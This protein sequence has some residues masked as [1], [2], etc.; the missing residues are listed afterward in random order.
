MVSIVA[1]LFS[2][3]Y[4]LY[5]VSRADNLTSKKVVQ[6]LSLRAIHTTHSVTFSAALFM[7][8]VGYFLKSWLHHLTSACNCS[9]TEQ[10]EEAGESLRSSGQLFTGFRLAVEMW[11]RQRENFPALAG[12]FY[13]S[14][15]SY[16]ICKSDNAPPGHIIK[17]LQ[18]L[19]ARRSW[20]YLLPGKSS[21]TSKQT[22]HFQDFG[23]L[24]EE[25]E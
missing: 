9:E 8:K 19:V 20:N 7:T 1:L 14:K 16:V 15:S 10:R 24:E 18:S 23:K 6:D 13:L 3:V 17:I 11:L 4:E 12:F 22:C 21:N 2:D 5:L 25:R